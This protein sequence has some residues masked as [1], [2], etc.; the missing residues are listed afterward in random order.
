MHFMERTHVLVHT[1]AQFHFRCWHS[2]DCTW[3]LTQA[4]TPGHA[5]S[6]LQPQF[7]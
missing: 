6:R 2:I 1:S 7:S 4:V 3:R 5:G